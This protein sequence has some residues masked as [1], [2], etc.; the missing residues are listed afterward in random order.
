[1]SQTPKPNSVMNRLLLLLLF[2]HH[3]AKCKVKRR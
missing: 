1:M 3:K 2:L